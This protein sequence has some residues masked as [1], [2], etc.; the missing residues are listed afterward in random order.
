MGTVIEDEQ[1][2]HLIRLLGR[3]GGH[4]RPLA[5]VGPQIRE[6][7]LTQRREAAQQVY[8]RELRR[9]RLVWSV[10]NNG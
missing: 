4:V 6:Q 3:R 5:E 7:I 2:W 9:N 8:L 10:L 1:G